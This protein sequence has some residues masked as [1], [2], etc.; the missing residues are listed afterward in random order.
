MS[1]DGTQ[2][3]ASE[4]HSRLNRGVHQELLRRA[5]E[6]VERSTAEP[7]RKQYA[8]AQLAGAAARFGHCDAALTVLEKVTFHPGRIYAIQ[9]VVVHCSAAHH[10]LREARELNSQVPPDSYLGAEERR[11]IFEVCLHV[12]VYEEALAVCESFVDDFRRAIS[13][14]ELVTV[15]GATQPRSEM[16]ELLRQGRELISTLD[17]AEDRDAVSA[18]VAR[19]YV[20]IDARD[21]WREVLNGIER[22]EYRILP[23]AGMAAQSLEEDLFEELA[24]AGRDA[25]YDCGFDDVIEECLKKEQYK[26]A[27]RLMSVMREGTW[28]EKAKRKI[29]EWQNLAQAETGQTLPA[30]VARILKELT[31]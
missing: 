9:L 20:E 13:I 12:K 29:L 15:F 24:S 1:V 18:Q 4:R 11:S 16:I 6:A 25:E 17:D 31:A 3:I 21:E 19:A 5:V 26:T 23:L 10:L 22:A 7:S 28:K 30:E 27:E 8:L 2:G 14:A